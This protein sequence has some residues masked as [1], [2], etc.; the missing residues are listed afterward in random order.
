MGQAVINAARGDAA[1]E[2][3]IC[4]GIDVNPS[5]GQAYGDFP[6]Y[7][8]LSDFPGEADVLVD[9]SNHKAVEG[10]LSFAVSEG[11]PVVIATTGHTEEE[12]GAIKR[13]SEKIAV[14]RSGNMSLGVNLLAALV[15]KAAAALVGYDIEIIEYHHNK[16]LDAP[17]GTALMLAESARDGLGSSPDYVYCRHDRHE[18]RPEN[19]IGIHSVRGGTIV[20]RHDVIFAGKNEVVTLSHSAES[21]D[22]FAHGALRAAAFICGKPAG[23]YCM[24]DFVCELSES[25]GAR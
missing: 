23:L 8:S 3:R 16:K 19:E 25:F 12:I 4:A 20:G 15:K 13:A 7:G 5:A 11:M 1:G 14:F 24:N 10:I 18:I 21:R 6:V 2:Y 9:F 22:I 17:S